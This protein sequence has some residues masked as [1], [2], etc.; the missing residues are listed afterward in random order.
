VLRAFI[1]PSGPPRKPREFS[2]LVT[3]SGLVSAA[4]RRMGARPTGLC[5]TFSVEAREALV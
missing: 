2:V 1:N 5:A 3:H 4:E